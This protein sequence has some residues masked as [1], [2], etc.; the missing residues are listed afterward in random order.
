MSWGFVIG[1]S[2]ALRS[3]GARRVPAPLEGSMS[4]LLLLA[5][6]LPALAAEDRVA[7][8]I[9]HG[10]N[11]DD[12]VAV[13]S[14][15]WIAGRVASSGEVA[16]LDGWSWELTVLDPCGSAS[17]TAVGGR[18]GGSRIFVGCSDATVR[19]LDPTSTGDFDVSTASVSLSG[20]VT[21][22]AANDSNVFVFTGAQSAGGAVA[23]ATLTPAT[24]AETGT[25]MGFSLPAALE[26][27]A[28]NEVAV[29]ATAGTGTWS[30]S[31][32]GGAGLTSFGF[33]AGDYTD[34]IAVS[35]NEF[36]AAAGDAGLAY[37]VWGATGGSVR[38]GSALG[39]ARALGWYLG[40]PIVSDSSAN[41]LVLLDLDSDGLPTGTRLGTIDPPDDAAGEDAVEFADLDDHTVA[42]TDGGS[43]W[44]ITDAPWV[45]ASA[46]SVA[47]G[48]IGTE[49]SFSFVSDRDG[50]Y[51]IRRGADTNT[52]GSQL[53][54]GDVAAGETVELAFTIEDSW[55]EGRNPL[56]I[57][58]RDADDSSIGHDTVYV[59]NDEPP[60]AVTLRRSSVREVDSSLVVQFKGLTAD[61]I[62][63]YKIFLSDEP[64]SRA[65]WADCAGSS[66]SP[67]GPTDFAEEDG[68]S[69]PVRVDAG[70]P[71]ETVEVDLSPLTNGQTYHIA[72]RAYDASGLEGSMSNVISGTPVVGLGPASLAGETG[73]WGCAASGAAGSGLAL[74][75]FGLLGALGRRRRGALMGAGL[76]GLGLFSS[77]AEATET[78]DEPKR[79]GTAEFRYGFYEPADPNLTAVMGESNHDVLWLEAGPHIIK[80][81]E[82]KVG[83]GWYQ[84]VD[85]ALS[86]TGG[87]TDDFAM[88]TALPLSASGTL[89][90]D[91]FKDQPIVPYA[92]AGVQMWPWKETFSVSGAKTNGGKFG[93]HWNAGGQILLDAFDR[94]AASKLQA[95]TG[96]DN[97]WLVVDFRDQTIGENVDGLTFSGTILGIGLKLDY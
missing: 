21:G 13:D 10:S 12:V 37:L 65:D 57:V 94:G 3:C 78:Y 62:D 42:V 85:Q 67:C 82:L 66:T 46:P 32:I 40:T 61:D 53:A 30:G 84:E 73:G 64:F 38:A 51:Q 93:W 83:L 26:D 74:G 29:M 96:I 80:Q 60:G 14:G 20:A 31:S 81:F 72:V 97:T 33:P 49:F 18:P 86:P 4:A 75:L 19:I 15:H 68:P 92:G 48:T 24:G 9:A 58:V 59:T 95:R 36:M 1:P 6:A 28:A 45:E 17:A 63:H 22:I 54:E 87:R 27:V 47:G 55:D 11:I 35:D 79:R 77:A 8:R 41:E 43:F 7:A 25:V 23:V 50:S 52:S 56:R 71:G 2:L 16:V 34:V 76:V 88:V 90:L 70:D 89:R 91:F 5:A 44:V 69:S 39:R